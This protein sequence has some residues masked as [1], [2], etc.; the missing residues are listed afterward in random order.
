MQDEAYVIDLAQLPLLAE[1]NTPAFSRISKV[2]VSAVSFAMAI[3]SQHLAFGFRVLIR[4]PSCTPIK[5]SLDD[6]QDILGLHGAGI[7]K[8]E[9]QSSPYTYRIHNPHI[10]IR[11]L[12]PTL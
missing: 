8:V 2:A 4:S 3:S 10:R 1:S 12:G 5:W 11:S 9:G 7:V 6:F